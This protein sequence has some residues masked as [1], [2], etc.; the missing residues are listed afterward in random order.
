MAGP[1]DG[2]PSLSHLTKSNKTTTEALS[3]VL[4]LDD[5]TTDNSIV[6]MVADLNS[7]DTLTN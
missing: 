1:N 4:H 3:S 7:D 6:D 2:E 5:D